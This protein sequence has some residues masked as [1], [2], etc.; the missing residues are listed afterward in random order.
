MEWFTNHYLATPQNGDHP[1]A[2]PLRTDD[3]RGLP[4]ALIL[5]AQYDP[6]RSEGQAYGDRLRAA[7]VAVTAHC[8]EGMIHLYLGP[9]APV[10]VAAE[11]RRSFDR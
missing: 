2:S 11:L 7:G 9:D 1:Y 5:T 8:L 6:L 4:P 10:I 3:L